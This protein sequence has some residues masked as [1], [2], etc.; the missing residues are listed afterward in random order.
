MKVRVRFET[1]TIVIILNEDSV[2]LTVAHLKRKVKDVITELH[3]PP[4]TTFDLSLN[5]KTRIGNDH[6]QLSS[7]GIVSGDL[8]KVLV[9]DTEAAETERFE[10]SV[11]QESISMTSIGAES[12]MDSTAAVEEITQPSTSSTYEVPCYHPGPL[13][14]QDYREGQPLPEFLQELYNMESV[15]TDFQAICLILHSFML[16][17]GFILQGLNP[18]QAP[19]IANALRSFVVNLEYTHPAGDDLRFSLTCNP[20]GQFVLIN[21]LVRPCNNTEE[22]VLTLQ[23]KSGEF[24]KKFNVE[25]KPS[26]SSQV[27]KDLTKLAHS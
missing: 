20:L 16:E 17:S 21:G 22:Q 14:L 19:D 8:L 1:R 5:G 9:I 2:P 13:L 15:K 12:T 27:F 6:E 4:N 7:I 26:D 11:V 23:I 10:E 18:H 3:L 24:V 25:S